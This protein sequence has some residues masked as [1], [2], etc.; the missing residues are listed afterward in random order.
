MAIPIAKT[1]FTIQDLLKGKDSLGVLN[2]D[3]DGGLFLIYNLEQELVNASEFVELPELN[4]SYSEAV[5]DYGVIL[6]PAYNG[7]ETAE[8]D[9]EVDFSAGAEFE[10]TDVDFKNGKM[11]ISVATDLMHD[12]EFNFI[13]PDLIKDGVPA[14]SQITLIYSGGASQSGSDTIFLEGYDLGLDQGTPAYNKLKFEADINIT[15][16]GNP[17]TGTESLDFTFDILEPEFSLLR[18]DFGSQEVFGFNDTIE[19][20][21]FENFLFGQIEFTNPSIGFGFDNSF[22][23]PMAINFNQ[24]TA[25]EEN[26]GNSESLNGQALQN[27]FVINA[28]MAPG[29]DV[30]S[31]L[32]LTTA[33]TGNMTSI[34]SPTPK[35]LIF[36]ISGEVNPGGGS[37]LNFLT[38]ESRLSSN[39]ELI[40]PLEGFAKNFVLYDT[41]ELS[42]DLPDLVESVEFKFGADN[43]FPF[44][45]EA[46]LVF[47]DENFDTLIVLTQPNSNVLAA[48]PVDINGRV[49]QIKTSTLDFVVSKE[50][51]E[52]LKDTKHLLIRATTNTYQAAQGEII[53]LYD[54]YSM[55]L[56]LG[57]LIKTGI[58]TGL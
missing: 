37:N 13:F 29:G 1:K 58:S 30:N 38:D 4:V 27:P 31:T 12:V 3:T 39:I 2:S 8:I 50:D 17:V 34:I 52:F 56:R 5:S 35:K 48:A 47:V 9:D 53:K 44:K 43:G 18:G 16:Q 23:V 20:K 32:T 49:S 7:T 10:L 14:T 41:L 24:I 36:D 6:S 46:D 21:L 19:I 42:L 55:E 15:G 40:M 57:M 54:D 33:N 26:T 22:G 11:S 28:P 51:A 25:V 45:I